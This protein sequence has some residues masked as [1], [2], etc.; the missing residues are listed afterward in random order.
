MT[1]KLYESKNHL[2]LLVISFTV[3][4]PLIGSNYDIYKFSLKE[5]LLNSLFCRNWKTGDFGH[6][7]LIIGSK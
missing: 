5:K 6:R 3:E 2:D 7:S 1:I 4:R